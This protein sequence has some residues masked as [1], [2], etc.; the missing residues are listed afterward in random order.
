MAAKPKKGEHVV[1]SSPQGVTE[2]EVVKEVTSTA[3]VKG[4]TAKA[5]RKDPQLLVKSRKTG[6]KALHKPEALTKA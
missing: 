3:S 1:W 4:H 6:K 2:G 5:T